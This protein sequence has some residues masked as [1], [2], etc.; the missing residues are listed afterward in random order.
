MQEPMKIGDTYHYISIYKPYRR[1][2]FQG[3]SPRNLAKNMILTYLYFGIVKIPSVFPHNFR[4]RYLTR[5]AS[6][7]LVGLM[8][9]NGVAWHRKVPITSSSSSSSSYNFPII[10]PYFPIFSQILPYFPRF[11]HIFPTQMATFFGIPWHP[12]FSDNPRW[13]R[14]GTNISLWD[15]SDYPWISEVQILKLFNVVGGDW[16]MT[17]I[18]LY[19]PIYW[20]CHH[21]KWRT[22]FFQRGRYTTNQ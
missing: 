14:C 20:A 21:P 17:F 9:E 16:N 11:S 15:G 18:F 12:L 10:F 1:P 5:N 13:L 4:V 19:F 22:Q 7:V 8:A 6:Q 2:T 3:I